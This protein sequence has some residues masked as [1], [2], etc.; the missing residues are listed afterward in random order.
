MGENQACQSQVHM[1]A[2]RYLRV[3]RRMRELNRR[4]K[5]VL[6]RGGTCSLTVPNHVIRQRMVNVTLASGHH[7]HPRHTSCPSRNLTWLYWAGLAI[8]PP[9][10][11][12]QNIFT[13]HVFLITTMLSMTSDFYVFNCMYRS[14]HKIHWMDIHLKIIYGYIKWI[15]KTHIY[16][17]SMRHGN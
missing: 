5:P 14:L 8:F 12:I 3:Q 2:L 15:R 1:T 11:P 17:Y 6:Q 7:A 10:P 9:T 16:M 4:L 13:W